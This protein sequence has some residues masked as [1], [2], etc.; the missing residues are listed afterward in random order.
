M[1]KHLLEYNKFYKRG[2]N[3]N[4]VLGWGDQIKSTL[5]KTLVGKEF[6]GYKIEKV[7]IKNP[8]SFSFGDDQ[9]SGIIQIFCKMSEKSDLGSLY[10]DLESLGV[11]KEKLQEIKYAI[12]ANLDSEDMY[13]ITS[14]IFPAGSPSQKGE[15]NFLEIVYKKDYN[16]YFDPSYGVG[17]II[18]D[19]ILN[20][21]S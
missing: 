14:E 7:E 2:T 11:V 15:N 10:S 20:Q 3:P 8:E 16:D 17:G 18:S 5:E 1:M 9:G 4:D 19:L 13:E 12:S 6:K 21:I